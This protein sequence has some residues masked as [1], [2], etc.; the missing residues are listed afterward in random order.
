MSPDEKSD[1]AT[2]NDLAVACLRVMGYVEGA[3]RSDLDQDNLLV[4][5]CCYQIAVMGEAVK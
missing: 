5:A 3:S 4:S 2:L 1:I